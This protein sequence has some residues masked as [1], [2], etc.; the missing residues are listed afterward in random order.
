MGI[1]RTTQMELL[2]P[3]TV[4]RRITQMVK[5]VQHMEI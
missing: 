1:R 3:S 4:T 2:L 5:L